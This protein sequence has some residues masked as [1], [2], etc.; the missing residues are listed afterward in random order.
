MLSLRTSNSDTQ[1]LHACAERSAR[2]C[3]KT[4]FNPLPLYWGLLKLDRYTWIMCKDLM[5]VSKPGAL[6]IPSS[7][8]N[9][10]SLR[11]VK[12]AF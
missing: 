9:F 7:Q 3:G 11:V 10:F 1:S 8:F 4:A 6:N 12:V 2:L 5:I